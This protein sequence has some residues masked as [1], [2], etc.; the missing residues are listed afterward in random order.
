MKKRNRLLSLL[1]SAVLLISLVP[2]VLAADPAPAPT[3]VAPAPKEHTSAPEGHAA[4]FFI[5]LDK[6]IPMEN[7][8]TDYPASSY[9]KASRKLQGRIK[10]PV[11]NS[12]LSGPAENLN[13]KDLIAHFDRVRKDFIFTEPK[14]EDIVAALAA[15][16]VIFDPETEAI[17]WYVVKETGNDNLL[18]AN[19]HVD[20]VIYPKEAIYLLTYSLNAEEETV[21]GDCPAPVLYPKDANAT[22][23]FPT[24]TRKGYQFLGWAENSAAE[25]PTYTTENLNNIRM[26]SNKHLYAIWAKETTTFSVW[27]YYLEGVPRL[28]TTIG[29]KS[30]WWCDESITDAYAEGLH[31]VD[32]ITVDNIDADILTD[33]GTYHSAGQEF[34]VTP[35]GKDFQRVELNKGYL[36]LENTVD[37][38]IHLNYHIYYPVT[39]EIDH[40]GTYEILSTGANVDDN[41]DD[42]Q[43]LKS[44]RLTVSY[45]PAPHYHVV[46]IVDNGNV[47]DIPAG[48]PLVI[49]ELAG[50]H[51]FVITT[52]IDDYTLTVKHIAVNQSSEDVTPS[53]TEKAIVLP[54]DVDYMSQVGNTLLPDALADLGYPGYKLLGNCTVSRDGD[55]VKVIFRY[56]PEGTPEPSPE[57]PPS[58]TPTDKPEPSPEVPPSPVPTDRPPQPTSRP[59]PPTPTVRPA[60]PTVTPKVPAVEPTDRPVTPVS[61][62][63]PTPVPQTNPVPRTPIDPATLG[64]L[65]KTGLTEPSALPVVGGT[66]LGLSA[67]LAVAGIFFKKRGQSK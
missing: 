7:G 42:N 46:S 20:G 41:P 18:N 14:M 52:K 50:Q 25:K 6:T 56:G 60:E 35:A 66:L 27:H 47:L 32:R 39:A 63:E 49:E 53:I 43:Y 11:F 21:T 58:P 13:V 48:K 23:Q 36:D 1:L 26:D 67:L 62:V 55:N 28:D 16:G 65:P 2:T 29:Y 19:Y 51:H 10:G 64:D 9:T 4:L 33:G 59:E 40:G 22:V 17:G 5:R 31:N 44:A 3:E 34:W 12:Q 54:Y 37:A 8:T 57:V 30:L 38:R 15:D 24:L 61:P 45:Q